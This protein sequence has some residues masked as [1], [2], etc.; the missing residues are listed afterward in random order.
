MKTRKI[1]Y[2]DCFSGVS[3][4]MWLGA[5]LDL[6]VPK[7]VILN[8][9]EELPLEGWSLVQNPGQKN[10]IH[11][12]DVR[13]LL[14]GK[15]ETPQEHGLGGNPN[16]TH[17]HS[18]SYASIQTM[19]K[20]SITN[21]ALSSLALEVFRRLAEAEGRIH[22]M[23]AEAVHFHEVGAKDA[24]IDIVG[25]CAAFLSLE[26]T[27]V[28]TSTVPL[29]N[30]FVTCA[31]GRIP[32]P[33]PATLE[34]LKGMA[35]KGTEV[36]GELVTPTGAALLRTFATQSGP[37]PPMDL[38]KTGYGL[39]N[40]DWPSRPNL[41]RLLLGEAQELEEEVLLLETN[42]DDMNPEWY[43]P[44]SEAL[45]DA[46]ALDVW[47][48]A[49]QMKK[50]RP[51][52]KLSLLT[53]RSRKAKMTALLFRESTTLGVRCTSLERD[54]RSRKI[55]SFESSLGPCAIKIGESPGIPDLIAPEYS[56]C[57][58][59]AREN[60]LPLREVYRRV[61]LE[62]DTNSPQTEGINP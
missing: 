34:L 4:D 59:L 22:G 8:A 45:F 53:H 15:E 43:D 27:E 37:C 61:L 6:G 32:I 19:L 36:E 28:V 31:H 54:I 52:T 42:L 16:G 17:L 11:G 41:L 55:V 50:G 12:T 9:L 5:F 56:D 33:A 49:I 10:G 26:V 25:S 46:G 30:G 1:L 35:T 58:R 60:K 13:V 62:F 48:T 24:I 23:P 2:I 47:Y 39:G 29:G 3:G 40:K 18:H 44:L 51:G 21:P 7:E 20:S 57:L 38:L 14:N